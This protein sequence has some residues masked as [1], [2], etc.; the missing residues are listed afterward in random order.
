MDEVWAGCHVFQR[1]IREFVLL[2]TLNLHPN[3]HLPD[4]DH[5]AEAHPMP[6]FFF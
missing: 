2:G 6:C 5:E 3:G 1:A 4:A